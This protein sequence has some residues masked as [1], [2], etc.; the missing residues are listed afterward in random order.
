MSWSMSDVQTA[1][2]AREEARIEALRGT[3]APYRFESD[4][5]WPREV[6][7]DSVIVGDGDNMFRVPYSFD[8]D[9][10]LAWG[11]EQPVQI[12][13]VPKFTLSAVQRI[14][15]SKDHSS[16]L[17]VLSGGAEV[18]VI[19]KALSGRICEITIRD[20]AVIALSNGVSNTK[21]GKSVQVK[22]AIRRPGGE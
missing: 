2:R 20:D 8:E 9:G 21:S 15:L 3:A 11:E 6:F 1:W 12:A 4:I 10:R 19:Q 13:Y 16:D 7:N 22:A 18:G 14:S 17:V 5:R